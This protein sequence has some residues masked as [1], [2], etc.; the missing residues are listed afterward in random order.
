MQQ[1][2]SSDNDEVYLWQDEAKC[3]GIDSEIFFPDRDSRDVSYKKCCF[4]CPVRAECLEYALVYDQYGIWGGTTEKERRR[5]PRFK[6]QALKDDYEE[7]GWLKK[8][9]A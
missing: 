4:D 1:G 9:K 7:S 3:I 2:S 6:I 8:F 5:I